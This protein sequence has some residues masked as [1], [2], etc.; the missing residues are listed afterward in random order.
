MHNNVKFINQVDR[1]QSEF[2]VVF[3]LLVLLGEIYIRDY[4]FIFKT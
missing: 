3:S 1:Y 4:V 2:V